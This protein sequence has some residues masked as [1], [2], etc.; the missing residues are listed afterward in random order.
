MTMIPQQ[1]I[2]LIAKLAL[3]HLL[4]LLTSEDKLALKQWLSA[5]PRNENIFKEL[6]DVPGLFNVMAEFEEIEKIKKVQWE[7]L[8]R[9]LRFAK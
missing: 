1:Q 4:N 9:R 3:K 6:T 2:E 7:K 5:S 8:C